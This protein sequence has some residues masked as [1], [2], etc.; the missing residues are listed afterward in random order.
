[1]ITR[2][3]PVR[4]ARVQL[5]SLLVATVVLFLTPFVI[6]GIA[7]C[8]RANKARI[9]GLEYAEAELR[10]IASSWDFDRLR[11]VMSEASWNQM[12]EDGTVERLRKT[13][14]RLGVLRSF[15]VQ[16]SSGSYIASGY[17]DDPPRSFADATFSATFTH[18]TAVVKMRV[19]EHSGQWSVEKLEVRE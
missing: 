2:A 8:P 17:T 12:S 14:T 6:I 11:S 15:T 16:R 9:R 10:A 1:M 13:A 5:R 3:H 19:A 7:D 4:R 18:G